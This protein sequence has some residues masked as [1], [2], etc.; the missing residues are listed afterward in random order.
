M[1]GFL[2]H[3]KFLFALAGI[4]L[5][6]AFVVP[7]VLYTLQAGDDVKNYSDL[8]NDPSQVTSPNS[9]LTEPS[10][11]AQRH[12]NTTI[13]VIVVEV[14]FVSL[15]IVMVYLGINHYHGQLDKPKVELT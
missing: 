3:H 13:I 5:L 15:F 1:C 8:I 6:I 14:V 2:M 4:F 11:V 7:I 10:E 12:T 9:S